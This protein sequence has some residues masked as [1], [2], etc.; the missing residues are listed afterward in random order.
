[1]KG[2]SFIICHNTNNNNACKTTNPEVKNSIGPIHAQY[3][4]ETCQEL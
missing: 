1:M 2:F 3:I 4:A